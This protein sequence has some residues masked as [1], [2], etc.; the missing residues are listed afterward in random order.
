MG[1]AETTIPDQSLVGRTGVLAN[2]RMLGLSP[3]R[4]IW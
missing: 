3:G 2:Y 1:K 4:K